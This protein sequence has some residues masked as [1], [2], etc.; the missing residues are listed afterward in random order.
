MYASSTGTAVRGLSVVRG[1][2]Y[3]SCAIEASIH[4]N[5]GDLT[6]MGWDKLVCVPRYVYVELYAQFRIQ[7]HYARNDN[8]PTR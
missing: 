3:F 1:G 7:P 5:K 6:W 8:R 2:K 4:R